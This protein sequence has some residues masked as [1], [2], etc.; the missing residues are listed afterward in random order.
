MARR[1]RPPRPGALADLS[2]TRILTQ[3]VLLQLAYYACAAVLIVFTAIVAGKEVSTDLLFNWR[4]LRGDTTVGWTLGLVWVLNSLIC[5][6]FIVLLIA[7]SKLV[8]DFALTIHFIHL[9]TTSLYSHAVPAN[10][11]WWMLQMCSA[12][13]MISVGTWACQWRELKPI[14]FGGNKA[15]ANPQPAEEDGVGESRGRGRGRGRDG[16]GEYEMA[17]LNE[18]DDRV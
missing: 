2:P 8:L 15:A 1:R 4:S 9:V 14:N 5:V 6:I 17:N 16:A 11:L 7:R 18:G 12:T 13:V 10:L 3:I